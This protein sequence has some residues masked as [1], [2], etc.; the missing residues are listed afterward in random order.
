MTTASS[1]SVPSES[2]LEAAVR[3]TVPKAGG[4]RILAIESS[5]DETAA[6][7]L[8]GSESL[9]SNVVHSQIDIHRRF[10]GVVPELASRSHVVMIDDVV[11]K[12]LADA[13]T[14]LDAIDGI[15]VTQGPGLVG[16][17][18]VGLE[19]GRALAWTR[20]IP[21]LPVHHLEGHLFA[22]FV[23]RSADSDE[24]GWPFVGLVVS[25][26]HSSLYH[27]K[28]PGEYEELGRTLDDAAGEAF[29]KISKRV[30]LGYP[31]GATIDRLAKDGNPDAYRFARPMLKSGNF[32][33]SFSG[34]KT[35]VGN[36]LDKETEPMEGQRLCDLAASFQEA[37]VDVLVAKTVQAAQQ[38]G[39]PRIV[40]TGGVA[41]NSRLRSKMLTAASGAGI[42]V[43]TPPPALCTDNAAMIGAAAYARL[44]AMIEAGEGFHG[45][46]LNAR[47]TWPLGRRSPL[48]KPLERGVRRGPKA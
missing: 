33:F 44:F 41:S 4:P 10:G 47:A 25:G 39:V 36:A 32:H 29:D 14:T 40:M 17:L 38:V 30:G 1:P 12:A 19:Y 48:Q 20:N 7:V 5:C 21:L 37:V 18:L 22:P 8:D 15:A 16:C 45:L 6:A 24:P 34:V 11:Q 28:A 2:P 26:G 27:C 43:V 42:A 3:S 9:L 13:H 35:A 31:G 46:T 23:G